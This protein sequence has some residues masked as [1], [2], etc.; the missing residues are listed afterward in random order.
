MSSSDSSFSVPGVSG[1]VLLANTDAWIWC[2][3]TLS[4][5]LLLGSLSGIST[6]SS[7]ATGSGCGGTTT[8]AD[9]GQELLDIL[10]LESL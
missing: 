8:R 4:L 10:A 9:G 2:V 5:C 1:Y 6:T 7:G 3:R